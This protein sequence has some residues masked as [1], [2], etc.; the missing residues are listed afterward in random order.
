MFLNLCIKC[1]VFWGP[2]Y[3]WEFSGSNCTRKLMHLKFHHV[4][5]ETVLLLYNIFQIYIYIYMDI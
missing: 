5:W 3:G 2:L 4:E 1:A